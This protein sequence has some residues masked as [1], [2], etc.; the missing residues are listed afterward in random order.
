MGNPRPSAAAGG[1]RPVL[2]PAKEDADFGQD[3]AHRLR[4]GLCVLCV[5]SCG[6][7]GLEAEGTCGRKKP[8]LNGMS[9]M[10]GCA[11]EIFRWG[12]RVNR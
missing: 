8:P 12:N 1:D 7:R 11:A 9:G 3:G 4:C 6:V 2:H 5:L 10:R